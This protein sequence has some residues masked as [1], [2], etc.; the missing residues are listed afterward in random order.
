MA[1]RKIR[2]SQLPLESNMDGLVTIGVNASN[3]SCKVSL[4]FLKDTVDGIPAAISA[5]NT[6]ATSAN[7]AALA[8][9]EAL[10]EVS[11]KLEELD[12]VLADLNPE[13]I[14]AW[15]AALSWLARSWDT[16]AG[17]AKLKF[18]QVTSAPSGSTDGIFFQKANG[19]SKF[20]LYVVA[21]GTVVGIDAISQDD[22][23]DA[24][25]ALDK[26]SVG[27]GNV[28]NTSDANKPISIAVQAAL[29]LLIPLEQKGAANGVATLG[30]DSK[31]PSSQL[32]SIAFSVKEFANFGS[33]PSSGAKDVIYID[34][35]TGMLFRWN[36]GEYE[37]L[38]SGDVEQFAQFFVRYDASQ[39]LS[40]SQKQQARTNIGAAADSVVVKL[41][42]DQTIGG[43]KGFANAPTSAVDA[44]GANEL[45]RLSQVL[46]MVAE[47]DAEAMKELGMEVP[48]YMEA[49]VEDDEEIEGGKIINLG[50]T[51]Q[52][53]GLVFSSPLSATGLPGFRALGATDI[54]SLAISKITGLQTALDGKQPLNASLT[55]IA[56]LS[57]TSGLLRK[58]G[59]N[60]FALDTA[61]Y[62]T[63]NQ[64]ITLSGDLSGS[65]TTSIAATIVNGAVTNAK[66]ATIAAN[67]IKGRVTSGTGVVEDLSA[68]QVR[69]L[70]NVADGANN[71]VHPTGDGNLHVPANSTTNGGKFLKA[72]STAGSIAWASIAKADI[73]DFAHVHP[74]SE[75]TGLQTALDG[76]IGLTSPITGYTIGADGALAATDTVLQ[77]FGKAQGQ[78]SAIK[79]TITGLDSRYL[80]KDAVDNNSTFK[81]T[82]G[83]LEAGNTTLTGTITASGINAGTTETDI[84]VR[85][86]GGVVKYRA[87]AD[88]GV[89]AINDKDGVNEF[90]VSLGQGIRIEGAGDTTIA[91]NA[92]TR[93]I[94]INSVPGTGSGSSVVSSVFGRTGVILATSGDYNTSQVTENAGYLYFTQPRVLATPLTGYVIGSNTA[95]AATDTILQAFGKT[96][97]QINAKQPLDGD[98][99][100]IAALSGTTGFLKKTAADTWTLDTNTYITSASIP[101]NYV[102]TN[103]NQSNIGGAKS[104]DGVQTFLNSNT[105]IGSTGTYYYQIRI[106]NHASTS[107]Q[108]NVAYFSNA[109]FDTARHA[110]LSTN[111]DA[112]NHI[113]SIWANSTHA[114]VRI[115]TTSYNI[116]TETWVN[117]QG[118]LK[119]NQSITLSGDVVG[120]GTTAIS[121]TIA[122]GAVTFA[123]MQAIAQGSILGRYGSGTG[124]VQAMTFG[125]GITYNATTGVISATGSGGTVTTISVGGLSPLFTASV[126]TATSTPSVTF[127]AVSQN[128]N[129]VYA[130][131]STGTAAAPTFRALVTADIPNLDAAKITTGIIAPARL[132]SGTA[133]SAY[134]LAGDGNWTLFPT[135]MT[136]IAHTH[137]WA[138]ITDKPNGG[139]YIWN[140]GGAIQTAEINI[141]GGASFGGVVNVGRYV[142][143]GGAG[144]QIGHERTGSGFAFIDL[145]G[146]TTYSDW[147]FRI[148]RNDS[149]ANA[150]TSISHRGTGSLTF[151]TLETAPIVFNTGGTERVR[152]TASGNLLV[153]SNTD[154]SNG[155]KLQVNGTIY[156]S[157]SS[158]MLKAVSGVISQAVEG[159][160]YLTAS[161]ITGNFVTVGGDQTPIGGNKTWTG[162]HTFTGSN[163][164]IGTNG[165][166]YRSILLGNTALAAGLGYRFVFHNAPFDSLVRYVTISNYDDAGNHISSL[167]VNATHARVRIGNTSYNLATETWANA[168]GFIKANQTI[169]LSGDVTGS[170]ATAISATIATGAV[171]FA[172]IQNVAASRLLGR[173]AATAGVTQEISIG[174]GLSLNATT[175]VLSATG[176]GG[177]VTSVGLTM[178]SIFTV[179]NSPVTASGTLTA[180]LANQ[181]ANLV[182]ASPATGTASTP[183]FRALVVNDLPSIPHTKITGAPWISA[184]QTITL[185]GDI[186]GSGTTAITTTIGNSTVTFAKMQNLT[187]SRL[188][189]RYAAT[190]GDIQEIAIGS[191]LNLNA[192][193]GLLTASGSGGTVTSVALSMPSI[194]AVSNSPVTS[195]GT[196][197]ATLAVQSQ[198]VV[199]A[200]PATGSAAA[201]TFRSLVAAD[202]PSLDA[203]KIATGTIST[204]RLGSG[205]A[206][207]TTYLAGDNTWKT[208]TTIALANKYIAFGNSSNQITGSSAFTYEGGR[209]INLV[210]GSGIFAAGV[211]GVDGF[212]EAPN[213]SLLLQPN[214]SSRVIVDR[215]GFRV[216]SL[217]GSGTRF[218][219]VNSSGDLIA[220]AATI[221]ASLPENQIAYGNS[222][223]MMGGSNF[224]RFFENRYINIVNGSGNA[225]FGT[226]GSVAFVESAGGELWLE[227]GGGNRIVAKSGFRIENLGG[228]GT[229]MVVTDNSGNISAQS[230]P[231]GS[232]PA[233]G[234][235][236]IGFGNGSN[237]LSGSNAMRFLESRY[238]YIEAFSNGNSGGMAVGTWGNTAFLEAPM[239][240]LVLQ[241]GGGSEIVANNTFRALQHAYFPDGATFRSDAR[242]KSKITPIS[243]ALGLIANISGNSYVHNNRQEYGLIAQQV[244]KVLPHAIRIDKD[245]TLFLDYNAIH[246]LSVQAINELN[247]KKADKEEV[248]R[249]KKRVEELERQLNII[250]PN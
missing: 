20:R 60:T 194:F 205:T 40:S 204:A 185:S 25:D 163:I 13:Q 154:A 12:E 30:S 8:A 150:G 89:I 68:A 36:G 184:N 166:E 31:I 179:S 33:F 223:N 189:G 200:G 176:T 152:I 240:N 49:S 201:P 15:D 177:T 58:T 119:A 106:G 239:G 242:Y 148:I 102:S 66:L 249:L 175:G 26:E 235:Q 144:L 99:T 112:G 145:V 9:S 87:L 14:E 209:Y 196:L 192:T 167:Y 157:V 244:Q 215:G 77:A 191:G 34:A 213:G 72:S 82:L 114:R 54:P 248:E 120:T 121:T 69:T 195:F 182:F 45:T 126:A 181:N 63:A 231:S 3:N 234:Y 136:P 226:F 109:G 187:G 85:D 206:S 207:S 243:G 127:A 48:D 151:A 73:S 98:L 97:A 222:S 11:E 22:L 67:T 208:F 140:Q 65:G 4:E 10:G 227:A 224:L 42:A 203:S 103:G 125:T 52:A 2:I 190:S 7:S 101:T 233:L 104:W 70:L 115:G 137:L 111:D 116:A 146:D 74:I 238:I 94:T 162:T 81:L 236:Q 135:S 246:A 220:G 232:S 35:E 197:T 55:S 174:A 171:T 228:G 57:G 155:S 107:G 211:V 113:S 105:N 229:R 217:T 86:S 110:T 61:S 193:T 165:N 27:L 56:A 62:L 23:D 218:L 216:N 134:Y 80:R 141:S 230:I 76:K 156:Q 139:N 131:P 161:S 37:P 132:G 100:A 6:A 247:E 32:P 160:D 237:I 143:S 51:V 169:T 75:V 142:S 250:N 164:N 118:F 43:Q 91:F 245:D 124:A 88:L 50:F 16:G 221:S 29:D 128:A 83:Q 71:Y 5:A 180:T 188:M 95:I 108:G 78:I 19:E 47:V 123:K 90:N 212:I 172:K 130:G 44:T 219:Q 210:N 122:T 41:E 129:L 21:N 173:Y 202:I 183:T 46:A 24:I 241:S 17:D 199:F 168:Q 38:N 93:K 158:G 84:L 225:N 53:Q 178:P 214:T 92:A 59:A 153:G 138:Q 149:G 133:S 117:A 79:T 64:A 147:G 96:Q 39:S 198:N 186:S 170:G 1:L 159:V 18:S 28:D